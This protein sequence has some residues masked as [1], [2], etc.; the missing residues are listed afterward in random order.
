MVGSAVS[1]VMMMLLYHHQIR[2]HHAMGQRGYARVQAGVGEV[3]AAVRRVDGARGEEVGVERSG[4][5]CERVG[6]PV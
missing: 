4:G 1:I 2:T 3:S 6:R 5:V